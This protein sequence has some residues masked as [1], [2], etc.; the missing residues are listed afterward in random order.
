MESL[1]S[2]TNDSYSDDDSYGSESDETRNETLDVVKSLIDD[3][4]TSAP[5]QE[6][7]KSTTLASQTRRHR[8][9]S[10]VSKSS[11]TSHPEDAMPE[12]LLQRAHR[13]I[14]R[15]LKSKQT[16]GSSCGDISI[17]DD[18]IRCI[19]LTRI[20]FGDFHWR[21]A[22][23]HADLAL[24]YLDLFELAAQA[25]EHA[26][27]SKTLLTQNIHLSDDANEKVGILETFLVAHFA[28]GRAC[29]RLDKD[30]DAE[31]ALTKC[32]KIHAEIGK[33]PAVNMD[34]AREWE[35]KISA[36]LAR[37]FAKK[38]SY[39]T[40]EDE[41]TRCLEL[42]GVNY[43][44]ADDPAL[45]PVLLDLAKMKQSIGT[46]LQVEASIQ[47]FSRA[48]TIN[49]NAHPEEHHITVARSALLLGRAY[50]ALDTDESHTSAEAYM[51]KAVE[52]FDVLFNAGHEEA[53]AA[54][55]SLA[56]LLIRM[57]KNSEAVEV[58][59][60]KIRG[61]FEIEGGE[62]SEAM[63]SDHQL[64]G[65]LFI[66]NGDM[67]RGSAH[68]KKCLDIQK[69]VLGPNHRKTRATMHS[70]SSIKP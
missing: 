21:L 57:T 38:K 17:L 55:S 56:K 61:R 8:S 53:Q 5:E 52:S 68:L 30:A 70:L 66:A 28:F 46:S 47:V 32:E 42:I 19:A 33:L 60:T 59:K 43:G 49:L 1:G 10:P 3:Q 13:R 36:S 20:L 51:R 64:L 58:L 11:K 34:D 2:K 14:K 54:R 63:A 27:T 26:S 31:K 9:L 65:S 7:Q 45:V 41:F 37:L 12:T 48:H 23:A 15:L 4:T 62:F 67:D 40:A 35:I 44:S 25:F 22:R 39:A 24:A 69:M 50:A 16:F 18:F 6:K 29:A